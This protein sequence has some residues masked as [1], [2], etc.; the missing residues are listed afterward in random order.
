MYTEHKIVK[1]NKQKH[2]YITKKERHAYL[3]PNRG[4][5]PDDLYVYRNRLYCM[6]SYRFWFS[7]FDSR[8]LKLPDL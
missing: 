7:V 6:Y 4:A 1:K 3:F 2:I 8:T 5:N